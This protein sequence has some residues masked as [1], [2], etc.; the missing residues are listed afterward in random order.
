MNFFR[1]K[2]PSSSAGKQY[3]FAH[4]AVDPLASYND[5]SAIHK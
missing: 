3:L 1:Y 4:H 5:T 2:D